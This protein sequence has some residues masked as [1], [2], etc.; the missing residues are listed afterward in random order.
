MATEIERKFLVRTLPASETL[1]PG[2]ALRQG[3]LAEEGEVEVRIRLTDGVATLTVKA[4]RGRSRTEVE[5]DLDPTEA[6]DLWPHTEGRRIE[7]VRHEVRLG[8]V[9]AEVDVYGDALDGLVV[10]E[11]E[12]PSAT[13]ADGFAPPDWFGPELTGDDGWS[14]ASLARSGRPA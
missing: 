12:F 1:G 13:E 10:V 3:Y 6:E 2:A 4:G 5:A 11:V 7:K 8:P 14:N 9:V